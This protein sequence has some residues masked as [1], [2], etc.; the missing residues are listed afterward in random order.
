MSDIKRVTR[1]CN[2]LVDKEKAL[3]QY[4]E[5]VKAIKEEVLS[6]KR[7]ELPE[8][9]REFGLQHIGMPD[10]TKVELLEDFD[11]KIDDVNKADA[12]DWLG[13]NGFGGIIK[14]VVTAEMQRGDLEGTEKAARAL[15]Q[16]SSDV[17]VAVTIPPQTLRAFTREQLAKGTSLPCDLFSINPFSYIKLT[18]AKEKA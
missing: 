8:L 5:R 7:V 9:M 1:L 6:L 17:R 4:E 12:Y 10:G 18:L 2:L 3:K 13:K 16:Y 11:V 14:N 15:E